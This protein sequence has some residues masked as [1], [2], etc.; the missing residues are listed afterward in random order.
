ERKYPIDFHY[1]HKREFTI[2]FYIPD[3][4][5]IESL[6]TKASITLPE[7]DMSFRYNV[8]HFDDVIQIQY[9]Y[10]TKRSVFKAEAYTMLRQL[11]DYM[12]SKQG[13]QIVLRR[14]IN[15]DANE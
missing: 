1:L 10:E 14:S 2:M 15:P 13:E 8:E 3:G 4:Y 9:L 7:R 12:L 5:E 11:Y 6:P